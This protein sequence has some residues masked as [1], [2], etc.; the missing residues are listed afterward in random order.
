[1]QSTKKELTLSS[2]TKFFESMKHTIPLTIL[3]LSIQTL[4]AQSPKNKLHDIAFDYFKSYC[5]HTNQTGTV[6]NQ[7]PRPGDSTAIWQA[8][9]N[10]LS[11][12]AHNKLI[13]PTPLGDNARGNWSIPDSLEP[14]AKL[15][16]YYGTKGKVDNSGKFPL[17]IYLHGSGPRDAE[18]AT[19]L[20][21][22]K[23]FD[24][25]PSTY[26]IPQIP[27]EGEWY[28]WYQ[29]SKQWFLERL[30]KQALASGNIDPYRLYLFGISEGG[31]GSQ[32]LSAFYADYLA[33]AGPMAGGEPLKNAPAE[34]CSNIGF[35]L[36]T[37]EQDYGFYRNTLT[38]YTEQA[39][40]SLQAKY[41][42]EYSHNIRLLAGMGHGIDYSLT[43]P[44]LKTFRRTPSPMHY[45]WEDFEMDGR[46]RTGFY[47]L[48]VSQ[49]PHSDVNQ[50]TR[51][52][53]TIKD[54]VIHLSVDDVSYTCTQKD[55]NWGIE[56][57]FARN[58]QPSQ[59][60]SVTIFLNSAM[61]NLNKKVT[62]FL[63]GKKVYDNKPRSTIGAMLK[64][65]AT[66]GDPLRIYPVAIDL[67]IIPSN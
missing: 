1:M 25:A 50:R 54:N 66:F 38:T 23:N 20:K 17:F 28:R 22:C 53:F 61:A 24:D 2:K 55:P 29:R 31:Y 4:S 18:W 63:N 37:G 51:Y 43:T 10:F 41:P 30:I 67:Q 48:T 34:N 49:R 58:Y 19:G 15:N 59:S 32:R 44:W 26:F 62:I 12:D 40:D 16:F 6:Y 3:F 47:N 7:K 65:L 56:L 27:N 45:I 14:N 64:S 39:F 42:N 46:H 33:A 8:W 35:S 5:S 57:K 36:L 52:E 60:G 11:Q 13:V 21:I 9:K